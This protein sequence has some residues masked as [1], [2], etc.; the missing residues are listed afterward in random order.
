MCDS[1]SV[2]DIFREFLTGRK[3]AFVKVNHGFWDKILQIANL[4]THFLKSAPLSEID[5]AINIDAFIETG[6]ALEIIESIGTL[7][8]SQ[9]RILVS[10]SDIARPDQVNTVK[11]SSVGALLEYL[12]I[13][14]SRELA[15]V[16]KTSVECGSLASFLTNLRTSHY[17]IV[18][19]V[20]L[21]NS[22]K[23]LLGGKIK[24]I[25]IPEYTVSRAR[26]RVLE[27]LEILLNLH[28]DSV[29]LIQAGSF[30]AMIVCH[31]EKKFPSAMFI[32]LGLAANIFSLESIL[33]RDLP[34]GYLQSSK[35]IN[36]YL[37]LREENLN[38]GQSRALSAEPLEKIFQLTLQINSNFGRLRRNSNSEELNLEPQIRELSES[39]IPRTFFAGAYYKLAQINLLKRNYTNSFMF[40]TSAIECGLTGFT[41]P[42]E[43]ILKIS[44]LERDSKMVL[45]HSKIL[46]NECNDFRAL[47][48]AAKMLLHL[49]QSSLACDL[50]LKSLYQVNFAQ[51]NQRELAKRILRRLGNHPASRELKNRL[52]LISN[53]TNEDA[54]R[55]RIIQ[56]KEGLHQFK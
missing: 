46:A 3:S 15:T 17:L 31:L 23:T 54:I 47:Y 30:S 56:I 39:G 12:G 29:V 49:G 10:S 28:P 27:E 19:P 22:A 33:V 24:T 21:C 18:G 5:K 37:Q 45:V 42:H 20:L 50:L 41:A 6:Y 34:W 1:L 4:S 36:Q 7:Q 9:N 55:D 8:N 26:L 44:A 25:T 52:T 53:R 43:L 32:D 13:H 11:N 40:A 51:Y 48:L 16:F 35:I 38:N 2:E 14:K